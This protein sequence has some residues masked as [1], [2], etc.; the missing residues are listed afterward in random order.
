MINLRNIALVLLGICTSRSPLRAHANTDDVF[1]VHTSS[2]TELSMVASCAVESAARFNPNKRVVLHSNTWTKS[3]ISHLSPNVMIKRFDL[4]SL[5]AHTP[6]EK[7]FRHVARWKKGFPL[8]NLSNGIRL[9][10]LLKEGGTYLDTDMIVVKPFSQNLYR[11]AVGVEADEGEL[12]D[13]LHMKN[14][15]G[16]NVNTAA[17]LNF[18]RQNPFIKRLSHRF[19]EEFVGDK[20]GWNGPKLLSRTWMEWNRLASNSGKDSQIQI[21]S[22][23][24]LYPIKW[25][26]LSQF[27]DSISKHEKIVTLVSGKSLAVHLW[28]SLLK[29]HLTF[30][31]AD[32][33]LGMLMEFACPITHSAMFLPSRRPLVNLLPPPMLSRRAP[34]CATSEP[35]NIC[36]ATLVIDQ[37][38]IGMQFRAGEDRITVSFVIEIE[39]E[40]AGAGAFSDMLDDPNR[41]DVCMT[42]AKKKGTK[43]EQ[44]QHWCTPLALVRAGNSSLLLPSS[45]ITPGQHSLFAQLVDKVTHG[46]SKASVTT[47]NV[48]FRE[49]K[50]ERQQKAFEKAYESFTKLPMDYSSFDGDKGESMAVLFV[51]SAISD[52]VDMPS[53][54]F[55]DRGLLP[56]I[57]RY[58]GFRSWV[59]GPGYPGYNSDATFISNL[60][61]RFGGT[62]VFDLVVYLPPPWPDDERARLPKEVA[63]FS[64]VS[65]DAIIAFR[66]AE[67]RDIALVNSRMRTLNATLLLGTYAN[68]LKILTDAPPQVF[69]ASSHTQPFMV[70]HLPHCAVSDIYSS[71]GFSFPSRHRDVDVLIAG[72]VERTT[73][74]LRNRLARMLIRISRDVEAGRTLPPFTSKVRPH[75]GYVMNTIIEAEQQLQ[76]YASALAKSKIVIVTPSIHGRG[77]AKYVEAQLA[78]SLIIGGIPAERQDYYR[79]F[80]VEIKDTDSDESI[81]RTI[82][83]W[84]EHKEEREARVLIGWTYAMRQTWDHWL[85][86]LSHASR[87]LKGGW[88]HDYPQND[89]H[90][91]SG[92]YGQIIW[93]GVDVDSGE[94]F[95]YDV[96]GRMN[97]LILGSENIPDRNN[98]RHLYKGRSRRVLLQ[99]CSEEESEFDFDKSMMKLLF[100][101]AAS[102]NPEE[103]LLFHG[104]KSEGWFDTA[105]FCSILPVVTHNFN[106]TALNS[107]QSVNMFPNAFV[108]LQDKASLC[109]HLWNSYPKSLSKFF[110]PCF[111]LENAEHRLHLARTIGESR[112]RGESL[113][114]LLK[115]ELARGQDLHLVDSDFMENSILDV[116]APQV[117]DRTRGVAQLFLSNTLHIPEMLGNARFDVRVF[118]LITGFSSS[119]S[120]ESTQQECITSIWVHRNGFARVYPQIQDVGLEKS[121]EKVVI[122][123]NEDSKLRDP[124]SSQDD[125][126]ISDRNVNTRDLDCIL[127]SLEEN[128]RKS[129][130]SS[131]VRAVGKS[132][133]SLRKP[134]TDSLSGV[135]RCPSG[136]CYQLLRAD[137]VIDSKGKPYVV[138]LDGAPSVSMKTPRAD[139]NILVSGV[140]HDAWRLFGLTDSDSHVTVPSVRKKLAIANS[141]VAL[142]QYEAQSLTRLWKEWKNRGGFDLAVPDRY[143][144]EQDIEVKKLSAGM[145]EARV[146]SAFFDL[147][148]YFR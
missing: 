99:G 114:F 113:L 52:Y 22:K 112:G 126:S 106:F 57:Q 91:A 33:V 117:K 71:A 97:E 107:G 108:S 147:V 127:K 26:E 69:D 66:Q 98:Y 138:D 49:W 12:A 38:P 92:A 116:S 59:W 8:N 21:L 76:D 148:D 88:L 34:T 42:L 31:T 48:N 15:Y 41:V 62:T 32:S 120:K 129:L 35:W 63:D 139:G 93:S 36:D 100:H 121:N 64:R 128:R 29:T 18:D 17:F 10:I 56:A 43:E 3:A 55:I 103:S 75:P 13:V 145:A 79:Q 85:L 115:P 105:W 11:N 67:T 47:F 44:Y 61:K 111:E 60:Q 45:S 80:V 101:T 19:V 53:F 110:L 130:W 74:P 30:A 27:F 104:F 2:E 73:Y 20:W 144:F 125:C 37:P 118:A 81:I 70:A 4:E 146:S 102:R 9:A 82:I 25:H 140:L 133:L 89:V 96:R 141:Q 7:W 86:W 16:M 95:A 39:E 119:P 54:N 6:L 28:Q 24:Y 123:A 94:P 1:F 46:V 84:L 5:F 23:H 65:G 51:H 109:R 83:W 78:G 77:L 135:M 143:L 72:S 134:L 14:D 50:L 124:I 90:T 131:I 122:H 132:V 142:S 40:A 58:S 137:L 87:A 68:E 136:S